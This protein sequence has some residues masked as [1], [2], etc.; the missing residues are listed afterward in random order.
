MKAVTTGAISPRVRSQV[1]TCFVH[2]L[3]T[4]D[5]IDNTYKNLLSAYPR[6]VRVG[7][8]SLQ[9]ADLVRSLEVGQAVVTSSTMTN[10]NG[11]PTPSRLVVLNVRPRVT[12]HGGEVD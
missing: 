8:R 7:D 11:Q 1:D 6:E 9:Y 10:D 3:L 4:L 5:D 12:V 2:L